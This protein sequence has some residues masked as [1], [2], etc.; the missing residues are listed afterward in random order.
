MIR[1]LGIDP[2]SRQTGYGVIE[3]KG[4]QALWVASGYIKVDGDNL[5]LKLQ[6]IFHDV[7]VIIDEYAPHE[8]AVESVFMH[9]NADS[10]LKLGQARGAA[11]TAIANRHVPVIEYTPSQIKKS[12]VGRGNAAK[13]QIQLMVTALLNLSKAPQADAADALAA[14]LCHANTSFRFGSSLT[15]NLAR[16]S[17]RGHWRIK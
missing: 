15:K 17:K 10:A 6:K 14:A 4:A 16:R 11:I 12:I 13:A 7:N 1:V 8:A 2:G 9:R 5:A 3:M